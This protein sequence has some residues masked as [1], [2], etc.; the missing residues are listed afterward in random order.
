MGII[1]FAATLGHSYCYFLHFT[2][3]ETEAQKDEIIFSRSQNLQ[4]LGAGKQIQHLTPHPTFLT[5]ISAT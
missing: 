5:I 2:D 3:K 1:S 4:Y